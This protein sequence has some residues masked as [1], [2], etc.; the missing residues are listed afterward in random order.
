MYAPPS[1]EEG[2]V[3][4]AVIPCKPA[5]PLAYLGAVTSRAAFTTPS[6]S[7]GPWSPHAVSG[8]EPGA[9]RFSGAEQTPP[10]RPRTTTPRPTRTPTSSRAPL[11]GAGRAVAVRVRLSGRAR[12][13][14]PPRRQARRRRPSSTGP[15]STLPPRS[16]VARSTARR[17]APRGAQAR[18]AT[19]RSSPVGR[20][21][22]ART[23]NGKRRPAVRRPVGRC[24]LRVAGSADR[25]VGDRRCRC[26]SQRGLSGCR[27]GFGDR[28]VSHGRGLSGCCPRGPG[29][30]RAVDSGR[31]RARVA[32]GRAG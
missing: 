20:P 10:S 8:L 1:Y 6:D 21:E 5:G 29:A 24:R 15:T 25:L 22:R 30:G 9:L 28:A 12:T 13:P 17:A 32:R 11:R 27:A 7:A 23:F 31:A 18:G 14:R 4:N 16:G 2:R 3:R 26:S 19:A